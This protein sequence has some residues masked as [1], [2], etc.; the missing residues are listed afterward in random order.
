MDFSWV[1]RKLIMLEFVPIHS[2]CLDRFPQLPTNVLVRIEELPPLSV[3]ES[4]QLIEVAKQTESTALM[5]REK[6]QVMSDDTGEN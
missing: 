3:H 5:Q 4:V 2:I 6:R 1:L